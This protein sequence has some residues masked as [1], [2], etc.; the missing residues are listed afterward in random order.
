MRSVYTVA[1]G[2]YAIALTEGKKIIH[3]NFQYSHLLDLVTWLQCSKATQNS[4]DAVEGLVVS[5]LIAKMHL[6]S[7]TKLLIRILNGRTFRPK[8]LCQ[9]LTT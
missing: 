9:L 1:G 6:M 7:D 4:D 8:G 2:G 3:L 5:I